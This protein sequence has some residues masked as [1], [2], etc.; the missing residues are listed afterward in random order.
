MSSRLPLVIHR[1]RPIRL[2]STLV[3]SPPAM[4]SRHDS[5]STA[6]SNA[7]V[8]RR[9]SPMCNL[10]ATRSLSR[11]RGSNT[12]THMPLMFSSR[13]RSPPIWRA[14]SIRRGSPQP[15]YLSKLRS[16]PCE[17]SDLRSASSSQKLPRPRT[18][19]SGFHLHQGHKIPRR[20]P[21]QE[22]QLLIW[23][24]FMPL[25]PWMIEDTVVHIV[26]KGSTGRAV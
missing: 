2:N 24:P 16:L 10:V 25:N 11:R 19:V 21:L 12:S 23:W 5:R 6:T 14:W 15:I 18:H 22:R 7:I 17:K 13:T 8:Y 9:T 26:T 3:A 4:E 1:H 20:E